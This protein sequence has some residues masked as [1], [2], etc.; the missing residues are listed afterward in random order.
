MSSSK[1]QYVLGDATF[2]FGEGIRV[3]VHICNDM[4]VWGSGFV[5]A[6]SK[7]WKNP[8]KSYRAWYESK[9]EFTLGNVQFVRVEEYIFV[10]NLLGQSGI[11]RKA[12]D[13]PPVRYLAIEAGLVKVAD[14]AKN[15]NASIHM[16]RIGCG[17]AG[18]DWEI[19][20]K[21][22]VSTLIINN[23]NVVVYDYPANVQSVI[24]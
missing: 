3:I 4:G 21:I 15:N 9:I 18:G 8:E 24:S 11:R 2:P 6:L 12:S 7:R 1:I 13:P 10:A 22:I 17:L 5:L 14:F 19:V 23:L 16:P 20:E